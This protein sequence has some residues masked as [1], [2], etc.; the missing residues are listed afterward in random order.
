MQHAVKSWSLSRYYSFKQSQSHLAEI[1]NTVAAW[2]RVGEHTI[3]FY[4]P[5][6]THAIHHISVVGRE[7]AP[8]CRITHSRCRVATGSLFGTKMVLATSQGVKPSRAQADICMKS[9]QSKSGMIH[10]GILSYS[11]TITIEFCKLCGLELR[12]GLP[13]SF[14]EGLPPSGGRAVTAVT[15]ETRAKFTSKNLNSKIGGFTINSYLL[16]G[17][18]WSSKAGGCYRLKA[19]RTFTNRRLCRSGAGGDDDSNAAWIGRPRRIR[20]PTGWSSFGGCGWLEDRP[21]ATRLKQIK[22]RSSAAWSGAREWNTS[23]DNSS[24]LSSSNAG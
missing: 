24:T 22:G 12:A 14:L 1:D 9:Q 2:Q 23:S 5:Y 7:L 10:T 17:I 18:G 15:A 16:V 4:N 3:S 8:T 20:A 13:L 6:L 21:P 11:L 19:G